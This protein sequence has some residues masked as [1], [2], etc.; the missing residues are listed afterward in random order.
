[1]QNFAYIVAALTTL[2]FVIFTYGAWTI[3]DVS[4]LEK[5]SKFF[6]C[7]YAAC[8]FTSLGFQFYQPTKDGQLL[9]GCIFL[10]ALSLALFWSAA[11]ANRKTPLTAIYSSDSPK[12]LNRS[13][14]YAYIRHPF[15]VAYLLSFTASA[16]GSNH[17]VP[18]ACAII[19]WM[20]YFYAARAEEKKFAHSELAGDYEAYRSKTGM[21]LPKF[22]G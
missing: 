18:W 10:L 3:F 15:Y 8:V 17:V 19:A 12:M 2:N 22:W 7:S 13:G 21:F 4:H 9:G 16:V 5:N 6:A 14:P 1:M 11:K 20:N